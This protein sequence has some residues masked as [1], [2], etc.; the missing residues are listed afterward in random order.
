[1]SLCVEF[2]KA[3]N[4]LNP[5]FMNNVLTSKQNKKG[6]RICNKYKLDLDISKWNQKTFAYKSLKVLDPRICNNLPYLL[7]SSK[8]FDTFKN[9][10]K[11]GWKHV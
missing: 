3:V 8:N 10:L 4:D 1:M 6:L 11:T 7:K 5:N 9:L 2:D